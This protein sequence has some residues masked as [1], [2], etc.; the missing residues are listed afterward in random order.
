[1]SAD[2]ILLRSAEFYSSHDIEV[3]L[4]KEVSG[5]EEDSYHGNL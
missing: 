1:M 4:G 2:S 3:I 5:M